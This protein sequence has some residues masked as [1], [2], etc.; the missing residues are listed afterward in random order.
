MEKRTAMKRQRKD[1]ILT[2]QSD[3]EAGSSDGELELQGLEEAW[4]VE[5]KPI[6]AV[7]DTGTALVVDHQET[8]VET[9]FSL[10]AGAWS[11]SEGCFLLT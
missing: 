11:V 7:S 1:L 9:K 8:P 5:E 10:R 4:D 2:V 6:V 3:D